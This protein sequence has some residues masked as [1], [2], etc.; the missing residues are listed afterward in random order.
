M[1]P[2]RLFPCRLLGVLSAFLAIALS[3]AAAAAPDPKHPVWKIEAEG[4]VLYLCGSIHALPEGAY[5]LPAVVEKAYE[6]SEVVVLEIDLA[7]MEKPEVRAEI[8]RRM[9]LESGSLR[10]RLSGPTFE[11]LLTRAREA[12]LEPE[13]LARQKP[14]GVALLL[15]HLRL[16][17]LGFRSERGLDRYFERKARRD[18]KPVRGLESA[19]DQLSM[20][21]GLSR[22]DQEALLVDALQGREEAARELERTVRAWSTGN[23]EALE[24]LVLG[25]LSERPE[26]RRRLV[27]ERNRAWLPQLER[28][29]RS[30]KSHFVV[31]G[32][33]HL[34]GPEGLLALLERAGHRAEQL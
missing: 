16:E 15:A 25:A 18:G 10:E 29:L 3:A 6:Q 32:A 34:S 17:E 31:V 22:E 2:E 19:L 8:Q 12:G 1:G 30:S 24:A 4:N 20:L 7:E 11:A 26:A 13:A 33:G 27:S 14:W 23:L 21:D 28:F 9:R 5:P